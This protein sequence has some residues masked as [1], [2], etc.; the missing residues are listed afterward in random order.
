MS[1]FERDALFRFAASSAGC[2]RSVV[3]IDV[4]GL[5][6]AKAGVAEFSKMNAK[7]NRRWLFMAVRFMAM[8]PG[9]V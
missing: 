8:V 7:A 4:E 5:P 2:I 9:M 3:G 1:G 6:A